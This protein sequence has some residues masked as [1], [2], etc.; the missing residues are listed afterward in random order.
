MHLR[1]KLSH[2]VTFI[3]LMAVIVFLGFL[4]YP[5]LKKHYQSLF[6]QQLSDTDYNNSQKIKNN[7]TTYLTKKT[8]VLSFNKFLPLFI[9]NNSGVV[10]YSIVPR[11]ETFKSCKFNEDTLL[12][13]YVEKG[14]PYFAPI[15]SIDVL[16]GLKCEH[17]ECYYKSVR[18]IAG[19]RE[20]LKTSSE[21]STNKINCDIINRNFFAQ[22]YY[23]PI[24]SNIDVRYVVSCCAKGLCLQRENSLAK[25]VFSP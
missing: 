6:S 1:R 24:Y 19:Q 8:G 17:D 21:S 12:Q 16:D 4:D 10:W 15:M 5:Y 20:C 3:I 9:S 23:Y 11:T 18:L 14:S 7:I 2:Y 22:G 13:F 25:K